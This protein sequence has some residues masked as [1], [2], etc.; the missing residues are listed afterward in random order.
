MLQM[1][2]T[3]RRGIVWT[4]SIA[5]IACAV[6]VESAAADAPVLL[7]G[8]QAAV[9]ATDIRAAA[10][11][12]PLASRDA[13]LSRPENVARQA[14]DLYVRR[15]LAAEAEQDGL[16]R[17]PVVA[18]LLKQARERI[19]S[20][21]RLAEIDLA[22][23]PDEAAIAR[24]ARELYLANPQRYESPPQTRARHILIGRSE[25]GG[26]RER[27]EALLAELKAGA[28]FEALARE[29]SADLATAASGGDL[30]WFAAGTMVKEFEDA[31]ARLEWPGELTGVVETPFGFHV[32]RLEGRRAAGPRS[33]DEAR[34]A[35]EQEV[36]AALQAEA[37]RAKVRELLATATADP[38]AI[39]AVARSFT[40]P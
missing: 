27:A 29:R 23:T 18:A 20:D 21:A 34:P 1:I 32:A 40:R 35:I 2:S 26:A 15:L 24:R 9:D 6:A 5:V 39:E 11:R 33:F 7:K 16:D 36:R 3:R 37:R 8:P 14:E 17:D 10:Q 13:T 25:D 4:V 28:S 38:A 30:G 12:I 31:L 19:L 22:A